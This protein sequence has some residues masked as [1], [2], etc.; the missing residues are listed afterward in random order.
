MSEGIPRLTDK[1]I[2]PGRLGEIIEQRRSVYAALTMPLREET[3]A[4]N[5]IPEGFAKSSHFRH[6]IGL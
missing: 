2:T 3:E 4:K 1:D 5:G 6:I